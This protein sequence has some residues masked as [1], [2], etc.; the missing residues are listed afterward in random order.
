MNTPSLN[1]SPIADGSSMIHKLLFTLI[2]LTVLPTTLGWAQ[3]TQRESTIKNN[4]RIVFIGDSITGQG[5]KFSIEVTGHE[6]D[7]LSDLRYATKPPAATAQEHPRSS[8]R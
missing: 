2:A 3:T 8:H 6:G 5:A 1:N 4:D 7:V